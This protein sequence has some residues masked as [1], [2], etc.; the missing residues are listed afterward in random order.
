MEEFRNALV[1]N[2]CF[3]LG[4]KGEKFTWS[5]K[6]ENEIFMKRLDRIVANLL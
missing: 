3:D 6:Y 4:W 5:N 1:A 2:N